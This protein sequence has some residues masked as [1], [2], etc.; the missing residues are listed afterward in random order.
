VAWKKR[1]IEAEL[2]AAGRA[3]TVLGGRRLKALPV[4]LP[5]LPEDRQLVR[6]AKE[7]PTPPAYPRR[8]GVPAKHPIV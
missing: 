4:D 1:A 8:P 7:R 5:G 6:L 3:I 2:T